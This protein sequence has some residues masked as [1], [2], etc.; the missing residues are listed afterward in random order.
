MA[1]ALTTAEFQNIVYT[2]YLPLLIGNAIGPYQ[3][4]NPNVNPQLTQ[5]FSTA[6]FRVGHSQVSD[7]QDGVDNNGNTTFTESLSQAFL[8]TPAQDLAN[9]ISNLLRGISAGNAQATDVYAVNSLR[10]LLFAAN[11]GGT[12]DEMDLIAI[13][14]QRERD[15]GLGTLNQTRQ[16]LGMAP[17]ASFSQ[18]TSDPT[19][20]ANMASVYSSIDN[21]DPF[22]GGLAEDHAPGATVGPTFQAIIADQFRRLRDGDRF[23]WLNQ[24]FDP[25]AANMI[26]QT[27]LGDLILRLCVYLLRQRCA[28]FAEPASQAACSARCS[29]RNSEDGHQ[30]QRPSRMTSDG[31]SSVRIRNVSMI[32]PPA[33]QKPIC[34]VWSARAQLLH[35]DNSKKGLAN[36]CYHAYAADS[37]LSR[38]GGRSWHVRRSIS[39]PYR[40]RPPRVASGRGAR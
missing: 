4:Y 11:V 25:A 12:V 38:S 20:A 7:S 37:L 5:E 8:N 29:L 3:G 34:L 27:T 15:L 2:E 19:V 28:A 21:V 10:N 24:R 13:D 1:R 36:G 23:F 9:G 22:M 32:T 17:Y 31:I 6:A 14:I 18:L 30:F 40:R 33:M 39:V 16:A 26:A 35:P